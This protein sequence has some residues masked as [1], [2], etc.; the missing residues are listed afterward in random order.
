MGIRRL[1]GLLDVISNDSAIKIFE[2]FQEYL[3]EENHLSGKNSGKGL[4]NYFL[5]DLYTMDYHITVLNPVLEEKLNRALRTNS[6]HRI[7]NKQYN[8]LAY[9]FSTRYQNSNQWVLEVIEAV[10]THST[11]RSQIQKQ[12]MSKGYTPSVIAIDGFAKMGAGMMGGSVHFDDHPAAEQNNNRYSVV[13]VDSMI[14][15]L[16]RRGVVR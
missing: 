7:H 13:T 16:Q 2:N 15:Y 8:M 10:E 9:P 4:M 11:S 3:D 12:L 14:H 5:D 1:K 6:I